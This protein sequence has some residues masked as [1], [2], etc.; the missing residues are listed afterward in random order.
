MENCYNWDKKPLVIYLNFRR[1][2]ELKSVYGVLT[3]DKSR[4]FHDRVR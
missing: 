3:N 1:N 2:K 4:K